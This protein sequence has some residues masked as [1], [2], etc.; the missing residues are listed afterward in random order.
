MH[1]LSKALIILAA[2]IIF[3]LSLVGMVQ[4]LQTG[5]ATSE[6]LTLAVLGSLVLSLLMFNPGQKEA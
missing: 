3:G 1:I 4:A 5:I 6:P 2:L